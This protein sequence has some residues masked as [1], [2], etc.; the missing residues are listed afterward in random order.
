MINLISATPS[1]FSGEAFS[2]FRILPLRGSM[3]WKRRSRPCLAEPPAESPS[4]RYNSQRV[5][6]F[7]EQSASLPGKV[8][9]SRLFF[10]TTRSRALRA[11]SRARADN[12]HLSMI[13]LA[14]SG[15]S[16]RYKANPSATTLSTAG[17]ASALPSLPL[18]CPS[19]CGS[20]IF[21]LTMAVKPSRT[22]SPL[23]LASSS[24][25]NLFLCA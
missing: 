19:N 4:T 15:C 2:T 7:S 16:S 8:P 23:R 12:K 1:I 21:T 6:S 20:P 10:R 22:S 13:P 9:V 25:R 17:L 18:V 11:A 14:S 5:G 3:A 24:F